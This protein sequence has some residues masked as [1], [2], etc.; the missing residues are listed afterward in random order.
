MYI[1]KTQ[2]FFFFFCVI[3]ANSPGRP[4]SKVCKVVAFVVVWEM[5]RPPPRTNPKMNIDEYSNKLVVVGVGYFRMINEQGHAH[6]ALLI[7][8]WLWIN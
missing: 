7:R 1:L 8:T 5:K 4:R 6:Y 3:V 2:A